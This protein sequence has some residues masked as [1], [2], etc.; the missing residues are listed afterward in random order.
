MLEKSPKFAAAQELQGVD[1]PHDPITTKKSAE[2][3]AKSF[4]KVEK[5]KAKTEEK[6]E[7]P[8]E[9]NPGTSLTEP[10]VIDELTRRVR[11]ERKQEAMNRAQQ[12]LEKE[13]EHTVNVINAKDAHI[14]EAE[15]LLGELARRSNQEA[16]T[17]QVDEDL[18][19]AA[20]PAAAEKPAE[21]LKAWRKWFGP[22]AEI[23]EGSAPQEKK[24]FVPTPEQQK[25][26]ESIKA[27]AAAQ[28]A[29]NQ[30]KAEKLGF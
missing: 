25:A 4:D 22:L 24:M 27:A 12:G 9:T 15:G 2:Q 26:V 6:K 18:K 29:A 7:V 11:E 17:K 23:E 5:A 13:L 20:G 3:W 30:K 14:A 8:V 10:V 19:T 28:E 1:D 16:L 21:D